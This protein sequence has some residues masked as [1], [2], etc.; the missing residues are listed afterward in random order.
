MS[1]EDYCASWESYHKPQPLPKM[2]WIIKKYPLPVD[3]IEIILTFS[4][5]I[6][7]I[8]LL[9]TCKYLSEFLKSHQPDIGDF[10]CLR[11]K[12]TYLTHIVTNI[13]FHSHVH[14]WMTFDDEMK[15]YFFYSRVFDLPNNFFRYL[16]V[17]NLPD[18][19]FCF[20]LPRNSGKC[21]IYYCGIEIILKPDLVLDSEK[22]WGRPE[23]LKQIR[24][25]PIHCAHVTGPI[26]PHDK[27]IYT[28]IVCSGPLV[29]NK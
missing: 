21:S 20:T 16:P 11:L 28:I 3:L 14:S 5:P 8:R 26:I 22:S 17:L 12:S 9:S 4:S 6:S 27:T 7:R 18:N 10:E 29:F 13:P 19:Y 15:P 25:S 1:L 24:P 2:K 23:I